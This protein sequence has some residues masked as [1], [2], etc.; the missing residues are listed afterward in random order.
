M[1][2]NYKMT[3][4]Y[5]GGRYDGWQRMGKDESTNT[6]A[7]K[8][9]EV[10]EKMSN[11]EVELFCGSRTETGVHAY[12]QIANFKI[13]STMKAYEVQNYLNRYLPKD[14]GVIRLEEV[15]DR[16][17]SQLNAKSKT[18]IYRIDAKNVANVFERKYMYHTFHKLDLEA[19]K[20]AAKYF[21]GSHDYKNF[22]TVKKS[23][24]TVKTV[25]KIDIYDGGEEIQI[26]ITA[27]D[28]LHNM[29]RLMIGVLLDIG[30][31]KRQ[32]KEIQDIF[33]GRGQLSPPAESNG[34]FLQ[35]VEY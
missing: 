2:T 21:L 20:S 22:S 28:F 11:Q 3:I 15:D 25:Q 10:I 1:M 29:A 35:T 17:H 19:M 18:Y 31:G 27:D 8:L 5:D 23:K 32:P 16:F 30:N 34:L 6:I 9:I 4:E 13:D 12:G 7:C 14:I 24:S 26:T 33:E